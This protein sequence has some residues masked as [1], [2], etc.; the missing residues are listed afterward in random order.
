MLTRVTHTLATLLGDVEVTDVGTELF[1]VITA[2]PTCGLE[3]RCRVPLTDLAHPG[4]VKHQAE[5]TTDFSS[6]DRCGRPD[7]A[8]VMVTE[9]KQLRKRQ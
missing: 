6:H 2:R 4:R 3:E 7:L 5:L 1:Q 8:T 9:Q